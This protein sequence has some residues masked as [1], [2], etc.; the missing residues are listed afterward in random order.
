[1]SAAFALSLYSFQRSSA[2]ILAMASV[3]VMRRS[4]SGSVRAQPASAPAR[5]TTTKRRRAVTRRSLTQLGL[6]QQ[7]ARVLDQLL[8]AHE[9]AHRFTAVDDAVIVGQSGVHHRTQHDLAIDADR[10]L[11]DRVQ[12]EDADLRRV[13]DRR[14][15]Q[16]AEDAAVRDAEGPAAQVL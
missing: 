4:C 14:A 7:D 1:L 10:T 16:R 5:A 15:H 13:E 3:T 8:D 9:E 11:L 2:G 6:D 12:A